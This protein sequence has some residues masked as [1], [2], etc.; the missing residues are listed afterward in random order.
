M[1]FD[2]ISLQIDRSLLI[3]VTKENRQMEDPPYIECF[4][5]CVR[6]SQRQLNISPK[7]NTQNLFTWTTWKHQILKKEPETH[8]ATMFSGR[9]RADTF[10]AIK[11]LFHCSL[12]FSYN[13][14]L[15]ILK[16]CIVQWQKMHILELENCFKS[17]LWKLISCELSELLKF[18]V[19]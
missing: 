16:V 8:N 2:Y 7:N 4:L 17:C 18:F 5:L 3:V 11:W 1:I 13:K 6:V 19:L 15:H 12:Y 14:N 10:W 9:Y